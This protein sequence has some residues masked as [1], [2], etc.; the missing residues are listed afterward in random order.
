MGVVLLT[1]TLCSQRS[2]GVDM[3]QGTD[4]RTASTGV[5][6]QTPLWMQEMRSRYLGVLRRRQQPDRSRS[7]EDDT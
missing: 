5:L 1:V 7:W 6:I 2:F 4:A 3:A